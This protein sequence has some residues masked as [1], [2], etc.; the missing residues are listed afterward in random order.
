MDGNNGFITVESFRLTGSDRLRMM[1][2]NY[3]YSTGPA[4][5]WVTMNAY[6]SFYSDSSSTSSGFKICLANAGKYD[7]FRVLWVDQGGSE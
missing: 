5:I 4:D 1:G 6:S 3:Q 7:A 2:K